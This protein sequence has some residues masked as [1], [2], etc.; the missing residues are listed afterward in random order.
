MLALPGIIGSTVI[1][2]D[3]NKNYILSQSDASILTNWV[4][5]LTP[6]SGIQ[7]V[8]G[9]IGSVLLT[10]TDLSLSEV[11][12]TSDVGKPLSS[13]GT[14]A[15]VLKEDLANKSLN[16][17]LDADSDSKYPSVKAVKTYIDGTVSGSTNTET[18]NRIAADETL[19]LQIGTEITR[20]RAVEALHTNTLSCFQSQLNAVTRLENGL[21]LVGNGNN[22]ATEVALYGDATINN[23]GNMTISSNAINTDKIQNTS[24]SYSKIQNVTSNTILGRT[25]SGAGPVE[26]INTTG[27]A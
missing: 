4:E 5:L 15:L 25:S 13:A 21:I 1:R 18:T 11:D 7:S 20:A 23:T 10:K 26:E 17:P 2:T 24:V 19:G 9:K 3:T 16:L 27:S 6:A 8:N 12:N 14:A 22:E